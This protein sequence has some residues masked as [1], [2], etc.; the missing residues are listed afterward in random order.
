M[1]LS[2]WFTRLSD[3]FGFLPLAL[4]LGGAI[5]CQLQSPDRVQSPQQQFSQLMLSVA[6]VADHRIVSG[7]GFRHRVIT[8]HSFSKRKPGDPV[9]VLFHGDG[10]PV[11]I[12]GRV[13]SDPGPSRSLLL[14][15]ASAY[16]FTF[17]FPSPWIMIG[18]PCYF[19][20]ND[21][22]CHPGLWTVDR[23]HPD[24]ARSMEAVLR[25]L[26]KEGD[27]L[28]F[29]AYSGGAVFAYELAG[30]LPGVESL[31]VLAGNL[32]VNRW[33]SEHGFS[34]MAENSINPD[35]LPLLPCAIN[36]L[37]LAGKEDKNIHWQWLQEFALKQQAVCHNVRFQLLPDATHTQGWEEWPRYL[38]SV[39]TPREYPD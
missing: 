26:T 18:R 36:Q 34:A 15:G 21:T 37:Y 31:L 10:E 25:A 11:D 20:V 22:A 3:C 39:I 8:S 35:Q 2:G 9:I 27:R 30:K 17:P 7:A 1:P 33:V 6:E 13:R 12:R 29:V 14:K 23:Y 32:N 38:D 4:L 19:A 16:P 24:Y 28:V 5:G